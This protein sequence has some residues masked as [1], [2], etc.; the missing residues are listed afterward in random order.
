MDLRID[1]TSYDAISAMSRTDDIFA[2]FSTDPDQG[3]MQIREALSGRHDSIRDRLID[4]LRRETRTPGMSTID[5]ELLASQGIDPLAVAALAIHASYV[6]LLTP[7]QD[8][9]NEADAHAGIDADDWSR[10]HLKLGNGVHWRFK[11][12]ID[13]E[14]PESLVGSIAT[15]PLSQL[16]RHPV[17]DRFDLRIGRVDTWHD[18]DTM[19]MIEGRRPSLTVDQIATHRPLH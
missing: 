11:G 18:T 3:M 5:A 2:I 8:D 1:A 14:L 7:D 9:E 16:V 6:L 17:L 12:Q 13:V 4:R 15:G 10:S 19:I